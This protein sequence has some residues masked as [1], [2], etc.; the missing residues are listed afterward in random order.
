MNAQ[1][2]A[3]RDLV[4]VG[5]NRRV[6]AL[7]RNTGN[8]Q[9]EW[10]SPKGAGFVT[11]LVDGDRLI[12]SVAGYVYCLDPATGE[13]VWNN[14]LKGFGN[15]ITS[16]ASARGYAAIEGSVADLSRQQAGRTQTGSAAMHS[17]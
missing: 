11:L 1:E 12:V 16:L 4:F 15:G 17:R 9:W 13:V 5:L 10:K 3:V 6:I 7:D 8:I 2:Q 14:P